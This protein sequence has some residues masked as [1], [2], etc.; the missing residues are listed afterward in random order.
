[1][2]VPGISNYAIGILIL[3][4]MTV[5]AGAFMFTAIMGIIILWLPVVLLFALGVL[6]AGQR[7]T[8]RSW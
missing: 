7:S 4:A 6:R 3:V 2:N 1:M 8:R 5:T